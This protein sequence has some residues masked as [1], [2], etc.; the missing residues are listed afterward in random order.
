MRTNGGSSFYIPCEGD[1]AGPR[2]T[3]VGFI[4]VFQVPVA[5]GTYIHRVFHLPP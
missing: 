3:K 5:S 4:R 1:F 2:W